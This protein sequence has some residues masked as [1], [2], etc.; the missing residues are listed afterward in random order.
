MAW[1]FG[2]LAVAVLV[3]AVPAKAD[4][5]TPGSTGT[6]DL[7][8]V[9][10]NVIADT[11]TL[12]WSAATMSGQAETL[13]VSDPGNTFCAGCLDFLFAVF[14]NT[15]STDG[16]ERITLSSFTGFQTDVG[17]ASNIP[18]VSGPNVDPGTVD[19]SLNG[20]VVGFNFGAANPVGA[21]DCTAAL[22]VETN[23]TSFGAGALNVIDGSVATIASY[24]PVPEPAS[25][26]LLATG[27]VGL[28]GIRRRRKQA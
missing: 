18:C 5:V 12:D 13:V 22:V 16:A 2:L 15:T 27:L 11:G 28:V 14:I 6:P 8:T 20:S 7:F 21:G 4:I 23:A 19:R 10:F 26:A 25:L 24:A 1:V 9:P 17:I 3:L